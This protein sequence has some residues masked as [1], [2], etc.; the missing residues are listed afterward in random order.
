MNKDLKDFLKSLNIIPNDLS[1]YE[2]AFTHSSYN[3][4][5]KTQHHDYQRLE[6]I[7]DSVVG[8]AVA[9]LIYKTY[10]SSQEGIMTKIRATLVQSNSLAN[11][12]TKLG[13]KQ[14]IKIGYGLQ[15]SGG[16]S[17][18]ILE[19]VFEAFVGAIYLD[20]SIEKAYKFVKCVFMED[21]I[22]FK[23]EDIHDYKTKLQEEMQSDNRGN[24]TYKIVDQQGPSH[25]PVFVAE[26]YFNDVKLGRGIATSKKEAEQLAAKDA[27]TKKAV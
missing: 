3:G 7:G 8:F 9:D 13:L 25:S 20:Q 26:V 19:D 15:Q 12:A 27:L 6:F 22:N 10:S 4:Q 14:F 17:N 5:M 18:K 23:M 21:I 24:V 11:Y 16:I 1:L 2:M